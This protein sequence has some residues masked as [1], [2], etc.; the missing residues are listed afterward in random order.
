MKT[1]DIAA[2][3]VQGFQQQATGNTDLGWRTGVI[4]SW[5]EL[6]GLNSVNI[7]GSTFDNLRVLSTGAVQPLQPGDVVGIIRT[8]SQYFILGKVDA[9]G[10]GA[11]ERIASDRVAKQTDVPANGPMADLVGSPGPSVTMFVGSSRRVLVIHSC[12]IYVNGLVDISP[13]AYGHQGVQISGATNVPAES[14][15]TNAFLGGLTGT[16]GS[17]SATTLVTSVDG[18]NS[19]QNTFTCKYRSDANGDASISVNNRVLTVVPF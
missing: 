14:A 3:L 2:L 18:L 8:G 15:V 19:G 1:G 6:T 16:S 11:G 4:E 9:P 5:D 12:E 17:T 7:A 10:A 13:T